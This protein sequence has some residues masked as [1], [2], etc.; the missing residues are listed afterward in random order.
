MASH[1]VQ[2]HRGE[3]IG[4]SMN[5]YI[6]TAELDKDPMLCEDGMEKQACIIQTGSR[7]RVQLGDGKGESFWR[8]D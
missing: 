7:I 5:L 8:I 6:G 3:A 2:S 4:L 1:T